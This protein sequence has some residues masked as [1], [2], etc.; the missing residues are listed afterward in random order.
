ENSRAQAVPLQQD[1]EAMQLYVDLEKIRFGD[2]FGYETEIDDALLK[3]DYR[4]APLL[5]QPFVENAIVHGIAPSEK[6]G[7]YLKVAVRLQGEF[8]HYTIEDNGIGR[9][10]SMA[11]SRKYRPGHRSLGLAISRERIDLINRQHGAAG[12]LD[13]V[14]LYDDHQPAGTRVL[15]TIN[16]T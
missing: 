5:I 16:V 11:Y 13:I 10:E 9:T 8:I 6:A 1:M 7:L 2:K 14:D 4:V 15:L 3:G 12:T